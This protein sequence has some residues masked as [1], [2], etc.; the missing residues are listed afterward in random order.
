MTILDVLVK[1]S[2]LINLKIYSQLRKSKKSSLM[3][4]CIY[5]SKL[6][7][8][9]KSIWLIIISMTR[10]IS[11]YTAAVGILIFHFKSAIYKI[12]IPK[13]L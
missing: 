3:L 10:K 7:T 12:N 4:F 13:V 5:N 1:L 11:I 9:F 2:I 8:Y 6:I